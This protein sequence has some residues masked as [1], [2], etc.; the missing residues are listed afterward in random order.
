[1]G[2][3]LHVS[4]ICPRAPLEKGLARTAWSKNIWCTMLCQST[5]QLVDRYG[6]T[7]AHTIID[8]CDTQLVLAFQDTETA[9]YY[10]DRA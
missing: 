7:S 10:H 9:Q 8:S 3:L 5:S 4:G 6:E 1:M 2:D